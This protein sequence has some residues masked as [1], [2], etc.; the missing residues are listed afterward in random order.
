MLEYVRFIYT[1]ADILH[2]QNSPNVNPSVMI[3]HQIE[4]LSHVIDNAKVQMAKTKQAMCLVEQSLSE[5]YHLIKQ[6]S[7]VAIPTPHTPSIAAASLPEL[8]LYSNRSHTVT[9]TARILSI[10][11]LPNSS[12]GKAM[13]CE[14]HH[15]SSNL[16]P[17]VLAHVE[18]LSV[19]SVSEYLQ[20]LDDFL[21]Y[22]V[23]ECSSCFFQHCSYDCMDHSAIKSC[24][25]FLLDIT[26][27]DLFISLLH[28]AKLPTCQLCFIALFQHDT[29]SYHSLCMYPP[30]S[31][32]AFFLCNH[33]STLNIIIH[34]LRCTLPCV[35]I[36]MEL[37]MEDGIV[38]S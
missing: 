38:P 9:P 14:T 33:P 28:H 32:L 1:L 15:I 34:V 5:S 4:E 29:D 7:T 35:E 27:Y 22:T 24:P 31:P 12:N 37:S 3:L 8:I 16:A 26:S 17:N 36:S 25:S 30:V 19:P 21:L 18:M 11:S 2:R 20:N 13:F 6:L 23:M 10:A